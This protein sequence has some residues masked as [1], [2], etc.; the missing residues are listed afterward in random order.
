MHIARDG[1]DDEQRY[2]VARFALLHERFN[3]IDRALHHFCALQ[4]EG[5]LHDA[6]VKEA[7]DL[8]HR[9]KHDVVE[10][11]FCGVFFQQVRHSGIEPRSFSAND[12][13]G[14][15]LVGGPG[16]HFR[17]GLFHHVFEQVDIVFKRVAI[18]L[19][20]R[21]QRF[22]AF[23]QFIRNFI[24]WHNCRHINDAR[25][26]AGLNRLMQEDRVEHLAQSGF[27]AERNI[28]KPQHGAHTRQVRLNAADGFQGLES[29][30]AQGV[31]AAADR[32]GQRVDQQIFG[33]HSAFNAEVHQP[34]GD[35]EFFVGGHRHS[36]FV[37]RQRDQCGAVAFRHRHNP[38]GAFAAVFK[39]DRVDH[40]PSAVAFERVLNHI[41]RGGVDHHRRG[42]FARHARHEHRDIFA[43]IAPGV[44]AAEIEHV[45]AGLFLLGQNMKR[46]L[47]IIGQQGVAELARAGGVGALADIQRR[48]LLRQVDRRK[49]AGG[50]L[51]CGRRFADF[52]TLGNV[53]A[54]LADMFRRG[55]AAATDN[56]EPVLAGEL[57]DFFGKGLRL[58]RV[59]DGSV[60]ARFGHSGVGHTGQLGGPEFTEGVEMVLHRIGAGGAVEAEHIDRVGRENGCG[61]GRAGADQQR[62]GGFNGYGYI[63]H[64]VAVRPEKVVGGRQRRFN[65][66]RVLTGF[67]HQSVD[68]AVEQTLNLDFVAVAQLVKT[69]LAERGEL[70]A[71]TDGSEYV[72]RLV[73]GRKFVGDLAGDLCAG[74]ADF[75]GA[76]GEIV[77]AEC[78]GRCA[79]GVGFHDVRTRFEVGTVQAADDIGRG[80]VKPLIAAFYS[81]PLFSGDG[82]VLQPGATGTVEQ[83]GA[84]IQSFF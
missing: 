24:Q 25:V 28:G 35:R 30:V 8:L 43:L 3:Y 67:N 75:V 68:S 13:V 82:L 60:D 71:R 37:D 81:S 73:G 9:R 44:A 22:G 23:A 34:F 49:E 31:V 56:R 29:R 6:V 46:V 45:R 47:V 40:R 18:G 11:I 79:E 27:K 39:V 76:V 72:A 41:G 2:L 84:G 77:L 38:L 42:A 16:D 17:F 64:N 65:L 63:T 50:L 4:H 58:E 5:K 7:P 53:R 83:Q 33:V 62:S 1:A 57:G 21:Q 80:E 19:V 69:D 59:D 78:S 70:R 54:Q 52:P 36:F 12:G 48:G 26:H 55:A 10:N 51:R 74:F 66:Q 61:G 14:E 32:E 20:I 15:N